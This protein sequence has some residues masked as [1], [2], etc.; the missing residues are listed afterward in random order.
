MKIN[1]NLRAGIIV[2][3]GRCSGASLPLGKGPGAKS[4]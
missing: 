2:R 4:A 3:P 1:T